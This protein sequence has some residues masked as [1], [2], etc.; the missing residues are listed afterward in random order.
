MQHEDHNVPF[1]LGQLQA[2]IKHL[3]DMVAKIF[4]KLDT[5]APMKDFKELKTEVE[6]LKKEVSAIKNTLGTKEAVRNSWKNAVIFILEN[7]GKLFKFG[8][9]ILTIAATYG[10]IHHIHFS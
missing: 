6:D 9:F 5:Y 10:L 1:L 2:N 3:E 8:G 7:S 4:D